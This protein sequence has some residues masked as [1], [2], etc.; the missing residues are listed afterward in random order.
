MI[1]LQ[2]IELDRTIN[3]YKFTR[4]KENIGRKDERSSDKFKGLIL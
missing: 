4:K 3:M 2:E 1:Y